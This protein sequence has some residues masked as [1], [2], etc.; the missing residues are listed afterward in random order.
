[1]SFSFVFIEDLG[2]Q[3]WH[4]YSICA[5]YFSLISVQMC[6]RPPPWCAAMRVAHPWGWCRCSG[7]SSSQ[8]TRRLRRPTARRRARWTNS[9]PGRRWA[10]SF[11]RRCRTP[12]P[13]SRSPCWYP[14]SSKC[15]ALL[16]YFQARVYARR[17]LHFLL[18]TAYNPHLLCSLL[19]RPKAWRHFFVYK[20]CLVIGFYMQ[21]L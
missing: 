13:P 12:G 14:T 3:N 19:L 15:P 11:C 7:D 8:R 10:P 5:G 1:M 21:I 4:N 2:S 18:G 17:A 16:L 20:I 9:S 6:F